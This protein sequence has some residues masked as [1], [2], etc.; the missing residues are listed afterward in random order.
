MPS[1]EFECRKV[2]DSDPIEKIAELIYLTDPYIYPGIC[3][4][5]RDPVWVGFISE[6]MDRPD[7]LYSR[8]NLIVLLVQERIVG[9]ACVIP[10]GK[11]YSFA[12]GIS[13]PTVFLAR[14]KPVVDGYFDPVTDE[15]FSFAGYNI[16]NFC[17]D[18]QWRGK[19]L[20]TALMDHCVRAFGQKDMHL[21]VIADNC[22]AVA[23]YRKFGFRIQK[24]YF[25][26]SGSDLLLP[27]L[28]MIRPAENI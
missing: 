11:R 26:F 9:L 17:I 16:V 19:G 28:Q 5:P 8:D 25:G 3:L 13:I 4:S 27:C 10:C 2:L 18:A 24:E 15:T 7:N 20:G 6:C 23:L 12:E 14:L 21:D 1:F 22:P